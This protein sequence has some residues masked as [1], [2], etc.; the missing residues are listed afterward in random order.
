MTAVAE[1]EARMQHRRLSRLL[2][3]GN[4]GCAS[5]LALCRQKICRAPRARGAVRP[6]MPVTARTE[7][8]RIN[9]TRKSSGIR[10]QNEQKRY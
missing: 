6:R 1:A 10:Q 4:P 9:H 5:G 7:A 2:T 8:Q 3:I